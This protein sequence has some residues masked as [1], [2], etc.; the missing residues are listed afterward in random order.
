MRTSLILDEYGDPFK[1][2]N[3][4]ARKE[5]I[6]A[7]N[8]RSQVRRANSIE[9]TYDAASSSKEFKAYWANADRRDADS[10]NSKDV[11]TKLVSRSRYETANNGFVDGILQT[12]ATDLVGTGPQ[13][14]MQ[15]LDEAFNL[16]VEAEFKRWC[17][18]VRFRRKLWCMA[19]AKLQDGEAFAVIRE[20]LKLRHPVQIDLVLFEAEQCTTPMLPFGEPGYIDGIK[21]DEFGNPESYDVLKYHPGGQFGHLITV[22]PEHVPA[23]FVL[24]WFALR[25]PGQHRGVPELRSTLNVGA[26]ARRWRE[27]TIAAAETAADFA[28]LLK[29]NIPPAEDEESP[30]VGSSV[31]IQK[32]M[33]ATLPDG[34][35]L[36]QLRAEHPNS[37]YD[38]F[39]RAQVNEQARPL[40]MPLNKAMCD[41]S[42]SNFASGRLDHLTYYAG[43]DVAREDANDLVL[44]PLFDVWWQQ[45]VLSLGWNADPDEA[46]PH[47]W[48]WTDHA[49][50]DIKS[51]AIANETNLRSSATTLAQIYADLGY[52]GNEQLMKE[53]ELL[54][55][56]LEELKEAIFEKLY[57]SGEGR[58]AIHHSPLEEGMANAKD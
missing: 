39:H 14:R 50:A 8:L 51:Q 21:F 17:K 45:A 38:G 16:K 22:E 7:M 4:H 41:S 28:G 15:T 27:A 34:Y 23:K 9:A 1:T 54:G 37:E 42:Q 57:V 35:E 33:L 3:G 46:S 44:D 26:A 55:K 31:E 5:L 48:D 24:H 53:A 20:N 18:R 19:H 13:L 36:Q 52:D 6:D 40:S 43:M 56:T 29:S 12:Y 25:R 49:V 30:I 11:R 2:R 47:T 58:D 32:R 10:A